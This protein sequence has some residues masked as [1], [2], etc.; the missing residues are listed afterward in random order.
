MIVPKKFLKAR[1]GE[2]IRIGEA[3]LVRVDRIQGEPL[4]AVI[5]NTDDTVSIPVNRNGTEY[6]VNV[7][8]GFRM[9][10]AKHE[11]EGVDFFIDVPLTMP[12]E[13]LGRDY[14]VPPRPREARVIEVITQRS[15]SSWPDGPIRDRR[16]GACTLK[17]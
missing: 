4:R 1:Y 8:V 12:L 2:T 14:P 16:V 11:R 13:N 3:I 10:P 15:T 9:C 17:P 7:L 6:R 5:T